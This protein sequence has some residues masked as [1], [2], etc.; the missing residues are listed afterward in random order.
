MAVPFLVWIIV[1]LAT[2]LA[3]LAMLIGLTR[4]LLVLSRS[5]GEF[6]R[7]VTPVAEELAA[8]ANRASERAERLSGERPFGNS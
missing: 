7:A 3:L 2:I 8:E 4:H 1:G 5:L 6:R